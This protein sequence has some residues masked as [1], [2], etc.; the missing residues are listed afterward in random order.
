M[1]RIRKDAPAPNPGA[2]SF[3]LQQA[4]RVS[5]ISPSTIRRRADE[6]GL[7]L[8]RAGGRRMVDGASLRRFLGSG[9]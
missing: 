1:P 8:F 3:T 2:I 5:G 9:P 7:R 6:W 4:A